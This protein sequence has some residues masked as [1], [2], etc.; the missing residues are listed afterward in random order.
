MN[1]KNQKSLILGNDNEYMFLK[2]IGITKLAI[3]KKNL[4]KNVI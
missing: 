3:L 2:C 1:R 4:E